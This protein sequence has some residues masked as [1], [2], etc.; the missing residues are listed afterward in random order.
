MSRKLVVFGGSGFLGKRI[1]E[2]AVASNFQVVSLSR[3]GKSV[4]SEPWAKEVEW[5]SCNVFD[6]E[7]YAPILRDT[8]DIVHSLGIL[9]ENPDYKKQISGSSWSLPQWTIPSFGKNPLNAN[10][11]PSRFT[12]DMM[13]RYSAT[14]LADTF[15]KVAPRAKTITYISADR[16]FPLI[17][18]GYINS[19]RQAEQHIMQYDNRIRP[20][21]A[22]PGFMFDEVKNGIDARAQIKN[23]LQLL[24]CANE[25]ILRKRLGFVNEIARP[26]ISTQQVARSIVHSLND[27]N[28]HGVL[29]LEQMLKI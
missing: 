22:R 3:S 5:K 23:L 8:T 27:E 4:S 29:T 2:A 19:K 21:L 14:L 13:N 9:L 7:S 6:P 1:C 25:L 26:L 28:V 17:P 24:N 20:I 10:E 16:G 18:S 11:P 15:I 12:Y